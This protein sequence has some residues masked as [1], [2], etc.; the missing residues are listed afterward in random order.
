M[1]SDIFNGNFYK[2]I[3]YN[4]NQNRY[5]YKAKK[6]KI[7]KSK[8]GR[9][10]SKFC[11]GWVLRL[12]RSGSQPFSLLKI[13]IAIDNRGNILVSE[14]ENDRIQQLSS[15]G[16]HLRTVGTRGSRPLQFWCPVGITV[17]PHTGKVYVADYGNHRIQVLNFDLSYFSSF[18]RGGGSNNGEFSYPYSV[19]TAMC[20]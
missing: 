16:K 19:G 12:P 6:V 20:V 13:I 14:Y 1:Y 8:I 4:K 9:E 7:K 3:A 10:K 5:T 11:Q 18:G 15:T 2:K 17:H